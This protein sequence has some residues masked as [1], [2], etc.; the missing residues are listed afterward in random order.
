M[1]EQATATAAVE[2]E[3]IEVWLVIG[4]MSWARGDCFHEAFT[5]W[6]KHAHLSHPGKCNIWRFDGRIEAKEVYVDDFGTLYGPKA[7]RAKHTKLEGFEVTKKMIEAYSAWDW[8]CQDIEYG[9]NKQ[10]STA[11]DDPEVEA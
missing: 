2:L 7:D 6:M 11:F 8:M 10:F 4:E 3:E 9:G 5:N 1:T